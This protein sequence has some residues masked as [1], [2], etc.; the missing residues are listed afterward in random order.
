LTAEIIKTCCDV[1]TATLALPEHAAHCI[2]VQSCKNM[3]ELVQQTVE[4]LN[5]GIL[6]QFVFAG[7]QHCTENFSG[8]WLQGDASKDGDIY[9]T[10]A[11]A[12]S[13]LLLTPVFING[14][15][16]GFVYEDSCARYCRL[17]GV[18]PADTGAS[19][20]EQTHSAFAVTE[21]ALNSAGF[22]FTDIIRT[23]IYL[24]QLLEWYADFNTART[25]YFRDAG[26]FEH[27][28]PA[29]TGIGAANQ[30]DTAIMMDVL[31][32]QPKS[33]ELKIQTVV[34][35]LQNPAL[36]YKSSFSRA[37]EMNYPT[38]RELFISGTAS[39]DSAGKSVHQND[40]EKQILLTLD[41]VRAILRSRE[42]DW[43]NLFR[44]I[45]YFK[46][47][48]YLPLYEEIAEKAG[49]PRFPLAIS[50]ADVCRD[51]LLFEIEVD[52]VKI[53]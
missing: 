21:A 8:V 39:I 15:E 52:A 48:S 14:K 34:S 28:V 51:D 30:F 7:T 18:I 25:Q 33:A 24:D 40:P 6:S 36:D 23:W 1:D 37:I 41:V 49:I 43:R 5:A 46:D 53:N 44:G 35:P 32:V 17:R 45:A 4:K 27:M 20:T 16:T 42:M 9:S 22:R 38:H 2:T 19:R 10:Q 3:H 29:S 50:H 11:V 26:I 13:G 47:M 12:I 31:A